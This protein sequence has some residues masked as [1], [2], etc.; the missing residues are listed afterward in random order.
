MWLADPSPKCSQRDPKSLLL[1]GMT[2][3]VLKHTQ[4][5]G[6]YRPDNITMDYLFPLAVTVTC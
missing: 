1:V 4:A 6:L 2:D 3:K 5:K